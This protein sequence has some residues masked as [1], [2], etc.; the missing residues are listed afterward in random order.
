[1]TIQRR[2]L[3]EA[4]LGLGALAA[5]PRLAAQPV[6]AP[7]P[8]MQ[9]TKLVLLGTMAGPVLNATRA[10][11]S[12]V[13]FVNGRG[14]LIDCGLGALMRLTEMGI[15]LPQI[16]RFFLTHHHSDHTADYPA[17][18]NLAWIM[19]IK[20]QMDVFGP[21]P[22]RKMHDA[23][24]SV[25]D[26]DVAI[27]VRATGRELIAKSFAVREIKEAGVVFEDAS[28]KVTAAL[29]VHPPFDLA[30]AYRFD[31]AERS[32]VISGDTAHA[33][34]VVTLAK[35]A[36]VLVHEAM[37]VPGIDAMLAKRP[38]VPPNL[39][40]FLLQ[41]HTPVEDVGRIAAAAKVKTLVLSHLLPGDEPMDDAVW[42][43]AAARHFSGEIIV[44]RDRMIL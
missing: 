30:L 25:F 26:E 19:G 40:S 20:G 10:M 33:E 36:D 21:P 8:W 16:Q 13:V 1:M 2:S 35:G 5:A 3:I 32:I 34:Q 7:K 28:V 24:L 15:G 42:I 41:G 14:H 29:A 11:S 4:A 44:G 12:Q 22:M 23:A 17:L 6:T 39:R 27:R 18:V 37:F 38:Y 31:T 43:T 9:G